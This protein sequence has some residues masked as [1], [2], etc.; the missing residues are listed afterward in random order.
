[1]V[2]TDLPFRIPSRRGHSGGTGSD[3]V[4]HQAGR[5]PAQRDV[6]GRKLNAGVRRRSVVARLPGTDRHVAI[7]CQ[8]YVPNA[9]G[10]EVQTGKIT[11][12]AIAC[13]VHSW[14]SKGFRR[15]CGM[16]D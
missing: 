3:G 2:Q 6:A 11:S 5:V 16:I 9:I 14:Y 7:L 1:M 8:D 15:S 13:V 10:G 12:Y 4:C